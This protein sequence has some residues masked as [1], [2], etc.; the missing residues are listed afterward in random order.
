MRNFSPCK[1][2]LERGLCALI[3]AYGENGSNETILYF[4]NSSPIRVCR[5]VKAIVNGIA[6]AFQKD[7]RLVRKHSQEVLGQRTMNPLWISEDIVLVPF[8]MRKPIGRED[9]SVGYIFESIIQKA[10]RQ[11]KGAVIILKNGQAL[12]VL[13]NLKTAVRHIRNAREL[14]RCHGYVQSPMAGKEMI[15]REVQESFDAPATRGDIAMLSRNILC[16]MEMLH[17]K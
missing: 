10:D 16:L 14:M 3:P 15:W 5:Q 17:T 1:D 11:D 12:P 2:W 6:R 4:T 13:D 8:K 9:G 7:I